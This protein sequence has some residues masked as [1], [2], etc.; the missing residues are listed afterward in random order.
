MT[1][2]RHN[3]SLGI[4]RKGTAIDI[5]QSTHVCIN[6]LECKLIGNVHP[7]FGE[8]INVLSRAKW[9]SHCVTVRFTKFEQN[10]IGIHIFILY[11]LKYSSLI[12]IKVQAGILSVVVNIVWRRAVR[13][14]GFLPRS[15]YH[16]LKPKFIN[17]NGDHNN[18]VRNWS[19]YN[20]KKTGN[21]I[22]RKTERSSKI[23]PIPWNRSGE[24]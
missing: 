5:F 3:H 1:R 19:T 22:Q 9:L 14:R 8:H 15:I 2:I 13:I 7:H 4:L 24:V 21:H 10:I 11:A 20:T 18:L 17:E 16:L 12:F 6:F 23:W